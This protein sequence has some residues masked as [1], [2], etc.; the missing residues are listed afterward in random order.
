MYVASMK[1]NKRSDTSSYAS[2]LFRRAAGGSDGALT[3]EGLAP[4]F[5][6]FGTRIVQYKIHGYWVHRY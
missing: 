5:E 2:V 3:T 1:S 4:H 6:V